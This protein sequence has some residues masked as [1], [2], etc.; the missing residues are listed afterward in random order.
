MITKLQ[1]IDAEAQAL[2]Y[3]QQVAAGAKLAACMMVPLGLAGNVTEIAER[4][5]CSIIIVTDGDWQDVTIYKY[6]F[7]R[8]LIEQM[9][10]E[11]TADRPSLLQVWCAGK[12]HGYSDFEIAK[13][14][15]EQGYIQSG[16][17]HIDP[18][19]P[20]LCCHIIPSCV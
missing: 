3:A 2:V 17:G 7:V 8:V 6:P 13:Y 4:E 19:V 14:L 18:N 16:F 9:Q 20:F 11:P 5:G 10:A 15:E 12:L 1:E